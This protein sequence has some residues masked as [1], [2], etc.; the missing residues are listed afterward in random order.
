MAYNVG[1]MSEGLDKC[2][3]RFCTRFIIEELTNPTQEHTH[4]A[5]HRPVALARSRLHTHVRLLA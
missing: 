3:I 2:E 4:Y 5:P 1:F